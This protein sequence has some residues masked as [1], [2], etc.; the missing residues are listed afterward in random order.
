[1]F[2]LPRAERRSL[3]AAVFLLALCV[4]FSVVFVHCEREEPSAEDASTQNSQDLEALQK[5][6]SRPAYPEKGAAEVKK[7]VFPFDPNQADSLTLLRLGLRPWQIR[8]MMRYRQKGG[9]WR[10]ADDFGRLYGLSEADFKRLRPYIRIYPSSS[11]SAE[12][13]SQSAWASS[14]SGHQLAAVP[15]S[16]KYAEGTLVRLQ[17]ADTAELKHIPGI[18]SYYARKI[19]SYRE[20]LGGYVRVSQVDEIE[21]LPSGLSRWFTLAGSAPPRAI[22]INHASFRQLVRHPYLNYEQTKVIV[23]HIRLYG[24]LH[25]WRDLRLYSE[26]SEA[27]FARLAPYFTFQ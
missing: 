16:E 23:N 3:L 20:R 10:S 4:V 12:S 27:D 2:F 6:L 22:R 8:N 21:G 14:P 25:G 13:T 19:V 1:M 7:E 24:P 9:H 18:G 26:F 15:R 17:E 11:P 5:E